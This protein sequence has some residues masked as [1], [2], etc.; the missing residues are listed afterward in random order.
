MPLETSGGRPVRIAC[1][2]RALYELLEDLSN[3]NLAYPEGPER[4]A[5]YLLR[6]DEYHAKIAACDAEA[7]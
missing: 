7:V 6:Q 5:C 1:R 2:L 4:D 3:C